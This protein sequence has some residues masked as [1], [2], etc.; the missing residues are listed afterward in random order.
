M[1][2]SRDAT[3][4][5]RR[6]ERM[7][8]LVFRHNFAREAVAKVR[9]ALSHRAFVAPPAPTRLEEV[10]EPVPPAA[11]WVVC[12]TAVSGI[13]GSDTKQIFLNGALDN[14][15]T[16]LLSFP[17][18]LG[19]EVVARRADTGERVVLNPWLSCIPR[20]IDP[21]CLACAEGRYPWCRN[22]DRGTVSAA[23]H[24]GNC[25][26]AP[27]AHAE[28][29]SAHTGQLFRAPDGV[30]DE[31]PSSPIPPACRCARFCCIHLIRPRPH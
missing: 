25:A 1:R 17:H 31:R 9:G 12:D 8:A 24:L 19:H 29:F 10:P 28:R 4:A 11:N 26:S 5:A 20:G 15:L 21:P 27:G 23:L 3:V 14:P 2:P 6:E 16:A 30:S 13:C 18:V 7:K 22:F